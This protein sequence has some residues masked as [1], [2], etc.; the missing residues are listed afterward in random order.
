MEENKLLEE[1]EYMKLSKEYH[2]GRRKKIVAIFL[3]VIALFGA[4]KI[5]FGTIELYNIFGYPASKARYY[6]VT[7]NDK[8]V[9]VSYTF[10]RKIPIIPYLVNFN[11]VYL[12]NSN[13]VNDDTGNI[14]YEDGSENYFININSYKCYYNDM[15]TECTNNNQNMIDAND[16]ELTKLTIT[17]TSNPYETV[18]EGDFINDIAPYITIKGQYCIE[19]T[20]KYGFNESVIHFYFY[21]SAKET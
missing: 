1:K 3:I 20:T 21:N 14:F 12:G 10:D 16:E 19:I 17:R 7:V 6:K 11:S 18:Y 13:I 9:A 5:F 4:I 8:Q 15:Q 2:L